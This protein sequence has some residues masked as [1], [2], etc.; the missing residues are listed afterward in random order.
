M[1]SPPPLPLGRRCALYID[2]P[3]DAAAIGA[4][5][6][7]TTPAGSRYLVDTARL[8]QPRHPRPTLRWQMSVHRLPRH[9][10]VPDDVRAIELRW[11]CR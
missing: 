3:E 11:Y 10:A 4:G 1:I 9:C 2:M 6:W 7:I 8:V 5:D